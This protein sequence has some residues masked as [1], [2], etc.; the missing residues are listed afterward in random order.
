MLA[1]KWCGALAV[2]L[3]EHIVNELGLNE[4]DDIEIRR[5]GSGLS[6]ARSRNP[7]IILASLEKFCGM[8]PAH[9]RL[10]RDEAN[11]R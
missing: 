8:L 6:A 9:E 5:E 11:E 4:G 2:L 3:P 1:V 10:S 7:D